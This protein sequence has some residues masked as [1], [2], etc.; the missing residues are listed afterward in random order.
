MTTSPQ[1]ETATTGS[2]ADPCRVFIGNL[3]YQT[4]EKE[5]QDLCEKHVGKVYV[6]YS[7]IFSLTFFLDFQ[8]YLS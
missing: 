4:K 5:L 7:I 6:F 1:T 3:N 8:I 2:V